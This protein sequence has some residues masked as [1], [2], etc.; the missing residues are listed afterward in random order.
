[1]KVNLLSVTELCNGMNGVAFVGLF[2][3]AVAHKGVQ[4]ASKKITVGDM[5]K[6][7][8]PLNLVGF[9]LATMI[10]KPCIQTLAHKGVQIAC[11]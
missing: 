10:Y 6:F 2:V 8:K 4:I 5:V 7:K 3:Q 11:P 1:M 9:G